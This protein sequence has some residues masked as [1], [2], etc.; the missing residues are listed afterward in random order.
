MTAEDDSPE[1]QFS[2]AVSQKRQMLEL[3]EH[4]SFKVLVK[5][6]DA[7]IEMRIHTM[8]VMPNGMDDAVRRIYASGEIAGLKI[9]LNF[10]QLVIEGAQGTI[11]LIKASIAVKEES[12]NG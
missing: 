3:I 7:Q 11:D 4:D 10:P 2:E 6:L 1:K 5:L 12:K 8:L 9:A